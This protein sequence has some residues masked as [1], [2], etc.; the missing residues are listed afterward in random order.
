MPNQLNFP[1]V[2]PNQ[3]LLRPSRISSADLRLIRHEERQIIFGTTDR[4]NVELWVYNANG[5][6][7]GHLNLGP[8][9]E[10]LTLTT[11]V[12]KSG[13]YELLNLDMTRATQKM[14]LPP[15]RYAM[16]ANFFRD[17]VGSEAGYKLYISDISPDRTE[18]Q[19]YPVAPSDATIK[20]IYEFVEPSVPRQYAKALMDQFFGES[21][22]ALP[23]ETV[24]SPKLKAQL[25]FFISNS[26]GRVTQGGLSTYFELMIEHL[27]DKVY[28]R[29]AV[30]LAEDVKN[31]NV[32]QIEIEKY[33]MDAF[34]WTVHEMQQSG[35]IPHLFQLI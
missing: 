18:V 28:T 21:L 24:D 30:L 1:D 2:L 15:G 32:Q 35:Q 3:P 26:M 17:E 10:A 5:M 25:D 31:H 11:L 20:D 22:D 33:I 8:T 4:D 19:L 14:A 34:D 7:A 6:F 12:D 29:S 16:V 9:D 23:A 13:P 27:L